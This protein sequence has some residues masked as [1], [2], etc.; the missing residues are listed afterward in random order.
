VIDFIELFDPVVILDSVGFEF[1]EK[2]GFEFVDLLAQDD[3]GVF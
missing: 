2:L 3:G 1:G